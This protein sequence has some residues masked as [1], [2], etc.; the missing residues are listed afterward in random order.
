MPISFA[1]VVGTS[2]LPE[3]SRRTKSDRM[4]GRQGA[5]GSRT[6]RAAAGEHRTGEDAGNAFTLAAWQAGAM[7]RSEMDQEGSPSTAG[8]M[9]HDDRAP[10]PVTTPANPGQG[11]AIYRRAAS[12]T[13]A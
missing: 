6:R 12:L 2:C 3:P 1:V 4:A 9:E 8:N 13:R 10:A 7:R 5:P 11:R